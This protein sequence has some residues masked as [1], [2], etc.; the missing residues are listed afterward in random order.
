V[1]L[2]RLFRRPRRIPLEGGHLRRGLTPT[3]LGTPS[4][5]RGT[6]GRQKSTGASCPLVDM[7]EPAQNRSDSDP[8]VAGLRLRNRCP[9]AEAAVRRSWF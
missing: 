5:S 3:D 6:V 1:G 7:V 2:L 4:C 9:Q 8:A